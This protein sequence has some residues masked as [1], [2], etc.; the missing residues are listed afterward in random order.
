MTSDDLW[1]AHIGGAN[2]LNDPERPPD[3]QKGAEADADKRQ[4]PSNA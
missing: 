2:R 1:P 3:R 4:I